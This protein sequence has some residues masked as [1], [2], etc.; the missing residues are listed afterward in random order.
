MLTSL[1]VPHSTLSK[2][3]AVR[4][5]LTMNAERRSTCTVFL[6]EAIA[7]WPCSSAQYSTVQY[8]ATEVGGRR[9]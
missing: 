7:E 5:W 3:F 9:E 4:A 1:V 8:I 6:A 2:S